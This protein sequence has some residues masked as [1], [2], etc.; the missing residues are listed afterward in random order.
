MRNIAKSSTHKQLHF[1]NFIKIHG[2]K[3]L[4]NFQVMSLSSIQPQYI[5]GK[6]IPVTGR[7][8]S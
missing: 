2:N 3:N 4:R 7:E 6:A 5:K 8:G 1:G